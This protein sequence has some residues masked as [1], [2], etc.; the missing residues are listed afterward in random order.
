MMHFMK[1]LC[2]DI[3]SNISAVKKKILPISS[4]VKILLNK[5]RNSNVAL[6]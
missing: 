5:F 3:T 1:V 2:A 4:G 6:L